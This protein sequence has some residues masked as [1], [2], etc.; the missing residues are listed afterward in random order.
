M[1]ISKLTRSQDLFV[2]WMKSVS[3]S[4][5][6]PCVPTLTRWPPLISLHVLF[7]CLLL[8]TTTQRNQPRYLKSVL[9]Q[10]YVKKIFKTFFQEWNCFHGR[11]VGNNGMHDK[12]GCWRGSL[13]SLDWPGTL[14]QTIAS[15]WPRLLSIFVQSKDMNRN[16]ATI[17]SKLDIIACNINNPYNHTQLP[18]IHAYKLL[19]TKS[20]LRIFVFLKPRTCMG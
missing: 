13:I 4:K 1:I 8:S 19:T 11:M 17:I 18:S 12:L 2:L 20:W 5:M 3:Y 16:Q 14:I 6:S 9:F 10:N 7:N 15:S